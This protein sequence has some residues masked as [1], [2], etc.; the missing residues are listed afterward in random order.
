MPGKLPDMTG[1]KM[2]EHGINDSRWTVL[3]KDL[4][5]SGIY[6]NYWKCKC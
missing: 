1:W 4:E 6:G 5:R 2:S 3:E